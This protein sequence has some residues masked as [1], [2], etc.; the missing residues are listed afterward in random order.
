MKVASHRH[1]TQAELVEGIANL[2]ELI[3]RYAIFELV[4]LQDQGLL[5]QILKDKVAAALEAFYMAALKYCLEVIQYS[6]RSFA[7]KALG[8]A[9]NKMQH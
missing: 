8:P 7:G 5:S 1:P 9:T 3:G 6:E 2:S 4:Y